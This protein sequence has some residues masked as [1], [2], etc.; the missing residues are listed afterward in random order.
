MEK[1]FSLVRR[2]LISLSVFELVQE[3][4]FFFGMTPGLVIKL[5]S[6]VLDLFRCVRDHLMLKSM[7][8]WREIIIN[9]FGAQFLGGIS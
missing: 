4:R 2:I 7:T 3:I 6:S 5:S 8:T 9:F 1:G